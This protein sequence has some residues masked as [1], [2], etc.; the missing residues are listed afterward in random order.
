MSL[1]LKESYK[2]LI[3]NIAELCGHDKSYH[4][5]LSDCAVGSCMKYY[6]YHCYCIDLILKTALDCSLKLR[7][8][9]VCLS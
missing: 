8:T 3:L 5:V 7:N 6:C 2:L 1:E 4:T 9:F